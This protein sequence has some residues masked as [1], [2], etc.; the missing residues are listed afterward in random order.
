MNVIQPPYVNPSMLNTFSWSVEKPSAEAIELRRGRARRLRGVTR[1]ASGEASECWPQEDAALGAHPLE[2]RGCV[3]CVRRDVYKRGRQPCCQPLLLSIQDWNA[4]ALLTA[5]RRIATAFLRW[6]QTVAAARAVAAPAAAATAASTRR[7]WRVLPRHLW[8]SLPVTPYRSP[9]PLKGPLLR[10]PA[11]LRPPQS[12][13]RIP[14][15]EART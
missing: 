11:V 4:R 15:P 3:G 12:C 13:P 6:P 14:S 9:S 7:A 10:T 1:R 2:P 5:R 8:W